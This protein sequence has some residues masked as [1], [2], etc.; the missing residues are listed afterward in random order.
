MKKRSFRPARPDPTP[1]KRPRKIGIVWISNI[2]E[3]QVLLTISILLMNVLFLLPSLMPMPVEAL[4]FGMDADLGNVNTSFRGEG[5][6]DSSGYSVAGAGDVNG[7]GY[8]DILIGAYRNEAGRSYLILG[9]PSGWSMDADLSTSDA[10]F[11]G[12]DTDDYS[13]LSVAGAGD[14]NGDGYDDIMIGASR[15]DDGGTDAGQSYLILGKPSGWAM[16]TDL[17]E[18]DASFLG[19]DAD[20]WSGISV[21]GAGDVN[22]DGYDDILIGAEGGNNAGQTYLILGKA[23]GWAMD[24]DLSASDAS[25]RGE[26][27]DDYFVR[28]DGTGKNNIPYYRQGRRRIPQERYCGDNKRILPAG[29]ACN[30][31]FPGERNH[32]RQYFREPHMVGGGL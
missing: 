20:D 21:T 1:K 29:H 9:K 23:S 8:D 24:T 15:N 30:P 18:S 26:D 10:S 27:A 4:D 7:D 3:G 28:S 6:L 32:R 25:F 11:P 13:G 19:E 5:D 22:G 14:V 16:D 17:S 2:K 31:L 12:E